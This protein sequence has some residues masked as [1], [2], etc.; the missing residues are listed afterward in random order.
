MGASLEV[1]VVPRVGHSERSEAADEWA[2]QAG[3]ASERSAVVVTP[4]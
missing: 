4:E 2:G 3:W 1:N